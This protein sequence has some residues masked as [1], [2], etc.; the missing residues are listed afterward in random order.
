MRVTENCVTLYCS[1]PGHGKK[2][3]KPR[4]YLANV[5]FDVHGVPLKYPLSK[6]AKN[7]PPKDTAQLNDGTFYFDPFP[8][9]KVPI[10]IPYIRSNVQAPFFSQWP[11]ETLRQLPPQ[12]AI[13]IKTLFL[14]GEKTYAESLLDDFGAQLKE[15]PYQEV[16]S[17][18]HRWQ[19]THEKS[20]EK[21]ITIQGRIDS[22]TPM[23]EDMQA[24]SNID[25]TIWEGFYDPAIVPLPP[26]ASPLHFKGLMGKQLEPTVMFEN[27]YHAGLG[28]YAKCYSPSLPIVIRASKKYLQSLSPTSYMGSNEDL[29]RMTQHY[30]PKNITLHGKDGTV[31]PDIRLIKRSTA[32]KEKLSKEEI[33]SLEGEYALNLSAPT[34][35]LHCPCGH[36][37]APVSVSNIIKAATAAREAGITELDIATLEKYCV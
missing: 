33:R 24:I 27:T 35:T 29:T 32:P 36:R 8:E 3:L 11:T 7:A 23:P 26:S 16:A 2:K 18:I 5:L 15:T 10:I 13:F 30:N 19:K 12:T 37:Y 20:R 25:Y 14:S 31:I 22:I 21:T 1:N 28:I 4:Y 17:K 9:L 6:R 34:V